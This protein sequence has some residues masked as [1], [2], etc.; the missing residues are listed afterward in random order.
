MKRPEVDKQ[1]KQYIAQQSIHKASPRY[2]QVDLKD[3]HQNIREQRVIAFLTLL[4]PLCRDK[5]H[6]HFC[7]MSCP[8]VFSRE[9]KS[10]VC[11][12]S[13]CI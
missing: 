12:S 13:L 3:F 9:H 10:L 7:R 4:H 2:M 8:E 1:G 11:S 5:K 6:L